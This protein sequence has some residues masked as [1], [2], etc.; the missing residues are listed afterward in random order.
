MA[1]GGQNPYE[2]LR[3]LESE[4][5]AFKA[6]SILRLDLDIHDADSALKNIEFINKLA[7][8]KND[9]NLVCVYYEIL[10]HYFSLR[11]DKVNSLAT[12]HHEKA[13]QF[14]ADNS[15][16]EQLFRQNFNLGNY[17]YT[18]IKYADAYRYF[19]QSIAILNKIGEDNVA[20][21]WKYYLTL[22]RYFYDVKDY[23]TASQLLQKVLVYNNKLAPRELFD[24]INTL[25]LIALYTGKTDEARTY[26]NKVLEKSNAVLDSAWMGIAYGNIGNTFVVKK[27]LDK[28]IEYFNLDYKFNSQPSGDLISALGSLKRMAEL[29]FQQKD[30]E[31]ALNNINVYLAKMEKKPIRYKYLVEAYDLKARLLD[32]LSI[33]EGQ[34]ETLKEATK[35]NRLF[36]VLNSNES[37]EMA[38][39]EEVKSN[40]VQFVAESKNYQRLNLLLVIALLGALVI[41]LVVIYKKTKRNTKRQF[42]V[43]KY[44]D[45]E[46]CPL[47]ILSDKRFHSED[48]HRPISISLELRQLLDG[49]LMNNRNWEKFKKSYNNSFPSFFSDLM[50]KYPGLTDADLRLLALINLHLSNKEVADRLS[51]SL[52]GIKKAKQRLKKKLS[53]HIIYN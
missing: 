53:E 20:Q 49:N 5:A 44:E 21:V 22:A 10:G 1:K 18:Y 14:A 12:M 6:F 31:L 33:Q 43:V 30:F 52:D 17:Y 7:K 3:G 48:L 2:E 35:Y 13:L 50:H 37:I 39:L 23:D 11:H 27:D 19:K 45:E 41:L 36:S 32:T 29:Q 15:L 40:Y 28:A 38:K 47:N 51:V 25:G 4:F 42:E 8:D 46:Y 26:F 16:D 24:A 34:L 9:K